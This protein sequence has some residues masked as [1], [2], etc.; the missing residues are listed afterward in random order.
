MDSSYIDIT[1]SRSGYSDITKRMTL[2][3]VKAGAT[4]DTG[5]SGEDAITG[6]IEWV[7][8]PV[9]S[10]NADSGVYT[11]SGTT[12]DFDAIFYEGTTR[13]AQERF[14]FTR[15]GDTWSTT[16]SDPSNV[17]DLNTSR[18]TDSN[19]TVSGTVA[20]TEITYT[21]SGKTA[22]M[23]ASAIVTGKQNE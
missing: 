2:T 6:V 12:V 9:I 10:K 7:D 15:S 23:S 16:V 19:A 14:R 20:L 21:Y 17:D 1:A 8:S 11:P 4:G 18:I 22:K 5:P 13:V 3:R